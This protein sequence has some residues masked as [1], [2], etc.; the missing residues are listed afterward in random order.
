MEQLED[1][2]D[3]PHPT[4]PHALLDK[5]SHAPSTQHQH[6]T[7]SASNNTTS[8]PSP[9]PPHWSLSH[10]QS[11]IYYIRH[12]FHPRLTR[13]SEL[14]LTRYYQQ[15]RAADGRS[16]A[17]TTIRLLESLVRLAQAHA[18]LMFRDVVRRQAGGMKPLA[19]VMACLTVILRMWVRRCCLSCVHVCHDLC[20]RCFPKMP[21]WPSNCWR[22][23]ST[24][25][26]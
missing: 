14:L 22:P 3:S 11:Y 24:P 10:M 15:Q 9:L 4:P 26:H 23:L 17:R 2:D 7:T 1:P 18:R 25:P 13:T 8:P 20:A 16:A 6:R 19:H 21:S 12:T 5:T